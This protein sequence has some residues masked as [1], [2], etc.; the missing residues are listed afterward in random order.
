MSAFRRIC[1]AC[2]ENFRPEEKTHS[3]CKDCVDKI[4]QEYDVMPT[5]NYLKFRRSEGKP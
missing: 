5:L 2:K 1:A 4:R 3:Y